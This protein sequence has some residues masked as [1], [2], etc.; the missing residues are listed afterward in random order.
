C[1]PSGKKT[2]IARFTLAAVRVGR[3]KAG[4]GSSAHAVRPASPKMDK[5]SQ[6]W[7]PALRAADKMSKTLAA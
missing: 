1:P 3:H 4:T 7:P 6:F 5:M 2:P